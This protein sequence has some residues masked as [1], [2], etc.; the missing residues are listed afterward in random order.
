MKKVWTKLPFNPY[1]PPHPV[2]FASS[3]KFVFKKVMKKSQLVKV[4]EGFM[5]N[6]SQDNIVPYG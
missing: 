1:N 3:V 2:V 6:F 4:E 5:L